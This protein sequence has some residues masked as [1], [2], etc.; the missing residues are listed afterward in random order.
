M[1]RLDELT[2]ELLHDLSSW[3]NPAPLRS[4]IPFP[5]ADRE[6]IA[7]H[8]LRKLEAAGLVD[9][10]WKEGRTRIQEKRSLLEAEAAC[11][12][13]VA[14]A[15]GAR[16]LFMRGFAYQ[17]LYPPGYVRQFNDLD[18]AI[19][20]E[21]ELARLLPELERRGYYSSRPPV[22]RRDFDHPG[23]RWMVLALNRRHPQLA[24]PL[25]L[26]LYLGGPSITRHTHWLLAD[27]LYE[28]GRLLELGGGAAFVPDATSCLLGFV[29]ECFERD[30][31]CARDF[32]DLQALAEAQPD[33]VDLARE[34][35]RLELG[36]KAL[37]LAAAAEAVGHE[38]PAA[39]LREAAGRRPLRLGHLWPRLWRE[40]R[41]RAPVRA[42]HA[43]LAGRLEQLE[44]RFPETALDICAS[45][46]PR[47]TFEL[48]LPLFLFSMAPG[49][50][51]S[52][53]HFQA[54]GRSYL[55]R[56]RP[57]LSEDEAEAISASL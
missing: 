27:E 24:E 56:C 46:P 9:G 32:L 51:C 29:V 12:S 49:A 47:L 52:R 20:S 48:G 28:R 5:E 42:L 31:L 39:L 54:C 44:D 40:S 3:P 50:D 38:L 6:K 8:V 37:E 15:V 17:A 36:G 45:L 4:A 43:A 34:I 13:E 57:L 18:L 22:V 19:A 41:V 16:H 21:A 14:A 7:P 2:P 10:Q 35:A 53:Q 23:G 55:A 26:D 1:P 30:R 33:A 11:L 25:M